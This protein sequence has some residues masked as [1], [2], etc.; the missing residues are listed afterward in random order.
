MKSLFT[1]FS[2]FILSSSV[3]AGNS[4]KYCGAEAQSCVTYGAHVFQARCAL[5]HGSDGL[6]EGILPLQLKNYPNTNLLD[7]KAKTHKAI[8]D[9][10]RYGGRLPE[11]SIEMPPWGDE[12]TR[13][14]VS[15]KLCDVTA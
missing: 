2:L 13:A 10:I 15:N 5:C 8:A 3:Y 11:T 4:E 7:G 12:L 1:I 6:G 9:I 14:G